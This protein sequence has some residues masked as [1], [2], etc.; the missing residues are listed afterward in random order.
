M[1]VLPEW[2]G[3]G[4]KHSEPKEIVAG[5]LHNERFGDVK[6]SRVEA[7]GMTIGEMMIGD[8]I[9]DLIA[10]VRSSIAIALGGAED[11]RSVFKQLE[12]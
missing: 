12:L 11:T 3:D 8:A 10:A 4:A 5:K 7:G 6:G 1:F 9:V 2:D